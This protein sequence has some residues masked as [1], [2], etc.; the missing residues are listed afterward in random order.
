[1]PPRSLYYIP[2]MSW[3]A[4]SPVI[5]IDAGGMTT[6]EFAWAQIPVF[7]AL[8]A[9]NIVVMRVVDDPTDP[10]YI[11]RTVPIQLGRAG[12]VARRESALSAPLVLVG[13]RHQYLLLWH[14]ADF[15]D[16]VPFYAVFE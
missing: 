8:I 16:P 1:V 12:D 5:L 15:L 4:V 14:R 6:A 2:L 13:G 9:A 11:R 7:G 10:R 3:V